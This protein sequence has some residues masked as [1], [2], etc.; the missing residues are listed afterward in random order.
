[1]SVSTKMFRLPRS[2]QSISKSKSKSNSRLDRKV[3]SS[4]LVHSKGYRHLTFLCLTFWLNLLLSAR[5]HTHDQKT[6]LSLS[7]KLTH[8]SPTH[9]HKHPWS[10]TLSLP[11]AHTPIHVHTTHTHDQPPSLSHTPTGTINKQSTGTLSFNRLIST[12]SFSH[13]D[14]G[15]PSH[16]NLLV[17]AWHPWSGHLQ[18]IFENVLVQA[19]KTLLLKS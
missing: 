9:P 5:R 6:S 17:A 7:L 2:N 10:K 16:Q 13:P 15:H 1:M 14:L 3:F 12:H 4:R 18:G 8:S 11:N 19:S